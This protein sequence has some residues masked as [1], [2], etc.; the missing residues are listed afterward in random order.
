[1][2]SLC[3][4]V[5][6]LAST[7]AAARPALA[8]PI[9]VT[10]VVET[11]HAVFFQPSD[12]PT[13]VW[14]FPRTELSLTVV[15]P[16]LPGGTFR[17][18]AIVFNPIT[19][20]DLAQLPPEWS[21]KSFVP[22]IIRPTTECVLTRLPEM[23]FVTQDIHALAHD[24]TSAN[25]PACRFSFR[26]PTVLTPDL[27]QRL[28]ALVSSDTLV[29]RILPL[30]LVVEASIAWTDVLDAVAAA[31]GD[32]PTTGLTREQARAAIE[33]ALTSPELAVVRAAVTPDEELA[34]I[35]AALA[36]LFTARSTAAA[37]NLVTTSPA[38]SVVYHV[39]P[40]QRLM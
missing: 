13:V 17:R 18:A 11:D 31:L 26:L 27:E 21:T 34:F 2:K 20:D 39:Q 36:N 29:T 5:L 22:F 28:D 14:F 19:A 40:F 7:A 16:Q 10:G 15:Q 30:G 1:M 4:L 38:G 25:P 24:V 33:D 8:D 37:L 32:G 35:D 3:S 9:R 23:R 6:V 12:F